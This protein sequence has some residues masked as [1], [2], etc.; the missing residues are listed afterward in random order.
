MIRLSQK[1]TGSLENTT[2]IWNATRKLW[3]N[4]VNKVARFYGPR[5]VYSMCMLVIVL[6][7]VNENSATQGAA[8]MA[9]HMKCDL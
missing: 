5:C 4:F 7:I 2:L 8:K 3:P 9:Q 1:T 6:R